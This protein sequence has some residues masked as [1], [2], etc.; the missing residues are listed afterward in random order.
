MVVGRLDSRY[1][2]IDRDAAGENPEFDPAIAD[3]NGP[4]AN[5]VNRYLRE[6]LKYNPDIRYNVW[7]DVRPWAQD[8]GT[9]VADMLRTAMRNNPYLKV[10]IQSGYYDAATDYFSAQYTISHI[11]PGGEFKD[12]FRFSHYESGHM[13]YL[14]NVDRVRANDDLRAFIRWCLEDRPPRV[15]DAR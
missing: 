12:R 13:M 6:E 8:E 5:A 9:N 14:R 15:T 7:G 11:Q 1:K 3:W 2:G 4:F 10:M